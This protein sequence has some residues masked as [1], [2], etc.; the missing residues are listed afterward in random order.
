MSTIAVI[1][2]S[3]WGAQIPRSATGTVPRSRK[4]S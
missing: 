2:W 1:Q 4:K 3:S